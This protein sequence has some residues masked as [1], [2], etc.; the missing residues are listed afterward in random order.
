MPPLLSALDRIQR[1]T[2]EEEPGNGGGNNN[3]EFIPPI[4]N[5]IINAP[6]MVAFTSAPSGG[7]PF[8]YLS[9]HKETATTALIQGNLLS[10]PS[11]LAIRFAIIDNLTANFLYTSPRRFFIP[12]PS[13]LSLGYPIEHTWVFNGT[14][15][16]GAILG[17]QSGV[18]KIIFITIDTSNNASAIVA[19]FNNQYISTSLGFSFYAVQPRFHLLSTNPDN[20]AYR[21][22]LVGN[23]LTFLSGNGLVYYSPHATQ[24]DLRVIVQATNTPP[25]VPAAPKSKYHCLFPN[26]PNTAY[27]IGD[28]ANPAKFMRLLDT[29][30]IATDHGGTTHFPRTLDRIIP[31][32]SGHLMHMHN[33]SS[34][35]YSDILYSSFDRKLN[36]GAGQYTVSGNGYCTFI[37]VIFQPFSMKQIYNLLPRNLIAFTDA[38]GVANFSGQ[39]TFPSPALGLDDTTTLKGWSEKTGTFVV[40]RFA[41]QEG[42]YSVDFYN[43]DYRFPAFGLGVAR[44][45]IAYYSGWLQGHYV[46]LT[47]DVSMNYWLTKSLP[48]P[49]EPSTPI[50]N[51]LYNHTTIGPLA[52]LL[53]QGY[54]YNIEET[55]TPGEWA[56]VG[57]CPTDYRLYVGASHSVYGMYASYPRYEPRY[58]VESTLFSTATLSATPITEITNEITYWY[59]QTFLWT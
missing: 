28:L 51:R 29:D 44:L 4:P 11:R 14:A 20:S 42:S 59:T 2:N 38:S 13:G 40:K 7:D 23:S 19:T 50:T 25:W 31:T 24:L 22:C 30:T 46:I 41:S 37:D 58:Y 8:F 9:V 34:L 12:V 39:A 18:K 36:A 15:I 52:D 55:V 6:G 3:G 49:S 33:A 10:S 54:I 21:A 16:L 1:K 53:P 35:N 5:S 43:F 47:N 48:N 57:G 17:V 27:F 26:F 32:D 56:D 45:G